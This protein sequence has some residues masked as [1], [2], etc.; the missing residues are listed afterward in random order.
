M[1][2]AGS[3]RAVLYVL[4]AAVFKARDADAGLARFAQRRNGASGGARS[5]AADAR[6][7]RLRDAAGDE[8]TLAAYRGQVLVRQPVGHL[9]R[10]LHGRDAD[11]RRAAAPLR[12]PRRASCR[13]VS[14]ARPIANKAMA[15]LARLTDGSLPFLQDMTRGV[16]FDAQ[17]PACR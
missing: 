5:A 4:F 2:A 1:L 8:T 6:R 11:A 15:E 9:V 14:T 17:A 12:G 10:A 3:D 13:S 7:A 16:L